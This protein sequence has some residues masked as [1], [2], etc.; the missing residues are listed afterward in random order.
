MKT[1]ETKINNNNNVKTNNNNNVNT[2]IEY[3]ACSAAFLRLFTRKVTPDL[4]ET[5]TIAGIEY[6]E[7][8]IKKFTDQVKSF[9][10]NGET[11]IGETKTTLSVTQPLLATTFSRSSRLS[12]DAAKKLE[13]AKRHLSQRQYDLDERQKRKYMSTRDVHKYIVKKETDAKRCRYLELDEWENKR[14]PVTNAL[15]F[16]KVDHFVSHN[17]DSLWDAMVDAICD[18]SDEQE[19]DPYYWVDIFA[20]NQ[21]EHW[22]N[23]E[24]CLKDPK[25]PSVACPACTAA[26]ED[27]PDWKTMQTTSGGFKQVISASPHTLILMEPWFR[28]R[29]PTRVWCLYESYVSLKQPNGSLKVLLSNMQKRKMQRDLRLV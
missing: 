23:K 16:G 19:G 28:P 21:G 17:W 6:L 27:M 14:D 25:D 11:L 4:K 2:T 13:E 18:H 3:R 24:H 20:V 12:K 29:P 7:K 15:Y 26:V 9:N 1:G 22:K 10:F 5:A 8:D